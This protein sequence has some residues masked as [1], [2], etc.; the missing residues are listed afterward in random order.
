MS[1]TRSAYPGL[2]KNLPVAVRNKAIEIA[3]SILQ[4]KSDMEETTI[5]TTAILRAK[6][7][8]DN[9]LKFPAPETNPG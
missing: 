8:A 3:N 6:E 9:Y 2:M 4:E 1:W 5:I 7:W